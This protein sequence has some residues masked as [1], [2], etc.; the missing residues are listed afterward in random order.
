M[1]QTALT[2][3]QV[4]SV[5][6]G[7]DLNVMVAEHIFG[8]RRISGPTHDYDGTVEQGEVLVPLGMSDAHAYA[9]M[10]PRGSIPIS[11]F[12]NRNWSED[13]YRAWMVIKQVEKEWAW[14]MKMYNGAGE[15]DVRIGRK[16]YSSE[17]VSEAICKA[18]LLAVLDI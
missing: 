15:V 4:L 18:A 10:P 14:E 1:T 6:P 16:D 5:E 11:Y 3:E 8:W 12:I 17:N 13:I 7:T 9:M 2:R